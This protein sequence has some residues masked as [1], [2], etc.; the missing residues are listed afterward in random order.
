MVPRQGRVVQPRQGWSES[1]C[2]RAPRALIR[3][4]HQRAPHLWCGN[5]HALP[6]KPLQFWS[7]VLCRH[8]VPASTVEWKPG[9]AYHLLTKSLKLLQFAPKQ[10]QYCW[11]LQR[12]AC[13]APIE[14]PA[15][16]QPPPVSSEWVSPP[17]VLSWYHN[18]TWPA[19]STQDP[20]MNSFSL[21]VAKLAE[22]Q[23][24]ERLHGQYLAT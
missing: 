3:P 5:G 13:V 14:Q 18:W 16:L 24:P 8:K 21:L 15:P 12:I 11:Q 9:A 23:R 17:L 1:L 6:A 20:Q 22:Q 7:E 10:L 2:L 4:W 19:K